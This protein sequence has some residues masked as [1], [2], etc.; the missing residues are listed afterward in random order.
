[1]SEVISYLK[2]TLPCI[3]STIFFPN[4]SFLCNP[5]QHDALVFCENSFQFLCLPHLLYYFILT[6]KESD[7]QVFNSD[8]FDVGINHSSGPENEVKA[9]VFKFLT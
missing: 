4:S 1:M 7:R 8:A 6:S 3:I 2:S 9:M 5:I